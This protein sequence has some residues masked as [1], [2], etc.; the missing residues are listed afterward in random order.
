MEPIEKPPYHR[1]LDDVAE[2][3]QN[4]R[5]RGTKCS[6]LIGAGCSV[7]AGIP[8]ASGFVE[9]IRQRHA[10]A[11]Q[12]AHQKTYPECMAM[13]AP[14]ERRALISSFVDH[15]RINWGHIGI[16]SL[17]KAG[18]IDRVLTTNFDPLVV[19][20]CALVGEFPAVYDVAASPHFQPADVPDRAIFYLHGQRTGFVLLNTPEEVNA[21]LAALK[22]VFAD[23]AR[24]RMWIVVGYSG[25]ND[26]VFELLAGVERYDHSLFWAGF[27]D[28]PPPAHVQQ[29][30]LAPNKWAFFVPGFTA[31][32]FFV[33]LSRK[34]GVFPPELIAQ[35]FSH[36]ARIFETFTPFQLDEHI[37]GPDVTSVPLRL[38]R[39][40][41]ETYE[42]PNSGREALPTQHPETA[43]TRLLMAGRYDDALETLN[44]V[45]SQSAVDHEVRSWGYLLKG[46]AALERANDTYADVAER[47][48][49]YREAISFYERSLGSEPDQP[50]VRRNIAVAKARAARL[51]QGAEADEYFEQSVALF[52][53]L[54]DADPKDAAAFTNLG[55]TLI[56]WAK[57]A[58]DPA[59]KRERL[60]EAEKA[61][62]AAERLN[63][64]RASYDLACIAALRGEKDSCRE[65]LHR[66]AETGFLPD[67]GHIDSDS[68]LDI[69]RQE[70]WFVALM[71]QGDNRSD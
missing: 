69:V 31:D 27:R 66:S 21:H 28:T 25:T 17:I 57:K 61:L 35:P 7:E 22:P 40:A 46:N 8:A 30:L 42:A 10:R 34:V 53:E 49:L 23:A 29:R 3:L 44:H 16:A 2:A 68:D 48:R 41:I 26:P 64:G 62:T 14:G 6:L 37:A 71:Q 52:G 36:L 43:A 70:D 11:Y 65:W 33:E 63:E 50:G 9:A 59:T 55:N 15:A 20:A 67:R 60:E 54:A 39:S 24:G 1:D 19:R 38:I 12:R 5:E 4:A 56:G 18:F 32:S 47:L 13:L 58:D 45:P 51:L